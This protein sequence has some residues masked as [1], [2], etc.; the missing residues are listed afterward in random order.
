MTLLCGVDYSPIKVKQV[1]LPEY[2]GAENQAIRQ[3]LS[4]LGSQTFADL[5]SNY[6]KPST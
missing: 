6:V 5:L 1:L 4:K 2:I 3:R